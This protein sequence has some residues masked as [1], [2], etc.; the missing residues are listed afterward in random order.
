MFD[1]TLIQ[2]LIDPNVPLQVCAVIADHKKPLHS[3]TSGHR[4]ETVAKKVWAWDT[5]TISFDGKVGT[6]S[7]FQKPDPFVSLVTDEDVEIARFPATLKGSGTQYWRLSGSV[8]VKV[9]SNVKI[10]S[11]KP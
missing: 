11:T 7:Q 4:G 6:Q 8:Q 5:V 9:D 1:F 2:Q 3:V 10:A